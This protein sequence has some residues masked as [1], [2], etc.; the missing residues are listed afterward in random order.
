MIRRV[1]LPPDPLA[2]AHALEG[3]DGLAVLAS[4][5]ESALRDSDARFSFVACDPVEISEDLVP[6]DTRASEAGWAGCAAAPRWIGVVPYEAM[7]A[8]LERA[9]SRDSRPAPRIQ[10]PRWKR[11]D[12]VIR[13][14]HATGEVAIEADDLAASERLLR[15]AGKKP[16][17]PAEIRLR[18]REPEPARVHAERVAA[19]LEYIARGDVYQVNL[20]RRLDFEHGRLARRRLRAALR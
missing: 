18:A 16:R 4:S 20:A 3:R 17:E 2:L 5:P 8:D 12:A 9:S 19:A 15:A 13:I 6:S 14:D 10:R 7:R 1:R 11:Y